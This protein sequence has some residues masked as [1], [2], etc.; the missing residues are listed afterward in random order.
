MITESFYVKPERLQEC[1]DFIRTL[2]SARFVHNPFFEFGDYFVKI[3]LDVDDANKLV[4]LH[5]KWYDEDK[6]LSTPIKS[7]STIWYKSLVG[8]FLSLYVIFLFLLINKLSLFT[9]ISF[10]LISL[11][12]G[13][14]IGILKDYKRK[15]K[16][17]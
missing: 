16:N 10:L 13:I 8:L 4:T 9:I 17:K 12:L 15:L 7:T 2:P 5:N 11:M 14:S 3:S 6:L 1:K